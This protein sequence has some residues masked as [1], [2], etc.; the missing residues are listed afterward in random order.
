MRTSEKASDRAAERVENVWSE[1]WKT[2]YSQRNRVRGSMRVPGNTAITGLARAG[3]RR[4]ARLSTTFRTIL[5]FMTFLGG[6]CAFVRADDFW[7][8]KPA[9]HW[10]HA[11]A[12]KLVRHSPWAKVEAVVFRR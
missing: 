10:S 7:K 8:H 12:L 6:L 5:A 1:T 3:D 4:A 2:C 11:E 9:S